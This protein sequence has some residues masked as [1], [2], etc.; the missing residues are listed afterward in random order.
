MFKQLGE[1][2]AALSG[3]P[4]LELA[5]LIGSR[6]TGTANSNSDWDF[7]IQWCCN[8]GFM[9]QLAATEKLRKEL[10]MTLQTDMSR[11]DLINIPTAR[12]AIKAVIAEEGVI[13]HGV[14]TLSWYHF[15]HRTWREL[16][17]A[18]WEEIYAA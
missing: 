9:E 18:Y 15:L 8:L 3:I 1:L 11:I 12:L 2:E 6:A 14:E 4:E 5:I 10:S 7:A 13:I 16:E 17:E